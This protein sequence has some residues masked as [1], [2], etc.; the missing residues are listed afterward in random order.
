MEATRQ[1]RLLIPPFVFVTSLFWG[2]IVHPSEPLLDFLSFLGEKKLNT[3]AGIIGIIAA[4]GAATI[5][6][7]FLITSVSTLILYVFSK[8][9]YEFAGLSENA[10]KR[11][12]EAINAKRVGDKNERFYHSATYDHWLLRTKASTLDEW[13]YRRWNVFLISAHCCVALILSLGIGII[14]QCHLSWTQNLPFSQ[15]FVPRLFL[16]WWLPH[17]ALLVVLVANAWIA[18]RQNRQM[19]NFLLTGGR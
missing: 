10:Y 15:L 13:L 18:Y 16:Y 4:G 19:F 3:V 2:A 7:G 9:R 8:G 5:S 14:F 11:M 1:F 17:I 6:F 12:G